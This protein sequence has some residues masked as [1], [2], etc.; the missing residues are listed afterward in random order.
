[1]LNIL[2]I[3]PWKVNYYRENKKL[4]LFLLTKISEFHK[5]NSLVYI[6]Q[7]LIISEI[8]LK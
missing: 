2:N 4:S 6:T 5:K 3:S 8:I 7:Y 1:M